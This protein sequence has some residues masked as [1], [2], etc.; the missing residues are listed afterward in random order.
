MPH[1]T[2]RVRHELIR[3]HLTVKRVETITPH[4]LR[5]Y[6][7]GS[8]LTG[9][10]SLAPDDH[11]KIFLPG[12]G[13]IVERR[14]Y[15]PRRY[16]ADANEL[17][18]DFAL[19]EAGPATAWALAAKPG[20][21]LQ[22]GGP[23]GSRVVKPDFDWWLL[24]GDETALPAIGRR[25]EE[26]PAGVAVTTIVAV[27]GPAEEQRFT[28]ATNHA[29]VWVHRPASQADD[30]APVLAALAA[31]VPPAG[32]GYVWIAAEASVARAARAWTTEVG[33]PAEWL[34]ASGYWK[35]GEADAHDTIEAPR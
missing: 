17:A 16:D 30:P 7:G 22:I 26:L 13:E 4:M 33:H 28:T 12:D 9:F 15:T 29:P 18:L 21:I 20:D 24:I 3:R 11:V 32:D 14:D 27:T 23:R 8:D 34:H 2:A 31:F 5:V 6:L 35:K 10:R 19:H 1:E 25:L